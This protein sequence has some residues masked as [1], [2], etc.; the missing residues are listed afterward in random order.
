MNWCSL[1]AAQLL[2]GYARRE[3]SPIEVIRDCA[4]G[5]EAVNPTINAFTSMCFDSAELQARE[6]ERRIALGSMRPLEGVPVAIKD[7]ID[8]AG[9]RTTYGSA[10]FA[11]HVPTADAE[12]VR[13]LKKSG[14]I[15]MGK[16]ATH[17]F[18]WGFTTDNPHWGATRNPWN[19]SR[20]PGGSSGGS[21]AAVAA[22]LVPLAIGTDTGG[23]IRVPSS[24]CG[25]TGLKT[26]FDSISTQ[27]VFP[28]APSLDHVGPIAREPADLILA[29]RVLL[30]SSTNYGEPTPRVAKAPP[31]RMKEVRLSV[32]ARPC[33]A[34]PTPGVQY[35]WETAIRA[36]RASGATVVE[37]AFVGTFDC[38]GIFAKIQLAEALH[39]HRRMQIYPDHA[40]AY[41]KDVLARLIK[42]EGVTLESYLDAS[43]E[44]LHLRRSFEKALGQV[45][46]VVSLCSAIS[47]PELESTRGEHPLVDLRSTLLEYT[48]PQNL[49]GLP[50]CVVRAGFDCNGMPVGIQF[51]GARGAELRVVELAE[52]FC[53]ISPDVQARRPDLL[54]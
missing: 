43:I 3:F 46:A 38:P 13:L 10:I 41:G 39:T 9:L 20:I 53:Q 25:V 36:L 30:D 28:L 29:L 33:G 37:D 48:T 14:A 21:A 34:L 24:F 15:I 8:T 6:S 50:A 7:L 49:T 54:N 27:G 40:S 52:A 16:T 18:A 51:T 35:V 47:A 42:A 4:A 45:D 11:N 44:R 32:C 2:S 5:I 22:E 31:T 17:E 19:L 26:S 12:V 1:S 23:S